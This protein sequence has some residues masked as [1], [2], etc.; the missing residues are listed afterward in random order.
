VQA[1]SARDLPDLGPRWME[2]APGEALAEPV[3]GT[4]ERRVGVG[5]ET[6]V[7]RLL[8]AGQP[9]QLVHEVVRPRG[10][11]TLERFT[12]RRV[13]FEEVVVHERRRLIHAQGAPRTPV[14]TDDCPQKRLSILIESLR[15]A[16]H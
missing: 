7:D 3:M 6:P 10:A 1:T 11:L 12:K 4:E 9:S 16:H 14:N 8:S 2:P 15:T 13:G 5:L